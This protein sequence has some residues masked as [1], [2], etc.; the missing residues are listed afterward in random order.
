MVSYSLLTAT[1]T[2]TTT[3]SSSSSSSNNDNDNNSNNNNIIIA[4]FSRSNSQYLTQRFDFLPKSSS[5][6]RLSF[7]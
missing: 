6:V 3:T 5:G 7:N 1:T 2:T 4:K